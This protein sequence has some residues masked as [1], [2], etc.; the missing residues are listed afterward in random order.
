[1]KISKVKALKANSNL[2]IAVKDVIIDEIE[3]RYTDQVEDFFTDL[4]NSGCVSGM[5]N[6]MIDYSDT[7]KFFNYHKD[8]IN[9]MVAELVD[10]IGCECITGLFGDKFDKSDFL[11]I[12]QSN[13]NL[14][15]MFGFEETAR[16]F[17]EQL[18]LDF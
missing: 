2:E 10:S 6:S 7:L 13:Q 3:S 1:M 14:L 9:A 8:E 4:M 15:A 18:G 17:A 5:I 12:D 11:C 16:K